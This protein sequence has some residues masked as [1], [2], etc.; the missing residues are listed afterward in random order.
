MQ[1]SDYFIFTKDENNNYKLSLLNI[2]NK[3][4]LAEI[5]KILNSLDIVKNGL[6]VDFKDVKEFDS[7][8]IIYLIS[9]PRASIKSIL[10]ERTPF[11]TK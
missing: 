11:F 9:L 3:D 6:I 5:I 8:A 1:N 7:A 4:T 2:W 10:E